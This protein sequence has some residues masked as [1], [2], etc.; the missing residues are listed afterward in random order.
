MLM[1]SVVFWVITRRRVVIVYR[2][3]GTTCRSHPHG[4]RFLLGISFTK[5]WPNSNHER[6]LG[7]VYGLFVTSGY[8]ILIEERVN[9]GGN[10]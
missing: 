4:S 3:F 2:R 1:K 8:V 10:E 6:G 5:Y 7:A 9:E